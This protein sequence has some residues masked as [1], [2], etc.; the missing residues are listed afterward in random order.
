M[1]RA[2][3]AHLTSNARRHMESFFHVTATLAE[4]FVFIYIGTMLFI[5]HQQW[6]IWAF[7]VRPYH[8]PPACVSNSDLPY[9]AFWALLYHR[10][11]ALV[12]DSGAT[13]AS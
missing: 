6:N 1:D 10:P 12:A 3:K 7:L 13:G 8:R 11:P 9:L 5:D 4:L 2:C